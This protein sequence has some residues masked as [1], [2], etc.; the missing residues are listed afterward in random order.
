L[1]AE[2]HPIDALGEDDLAQRRDVDQLGLEPVREDEHVEDLADAVLSR[3]R[4]ERHVVIERIV[5]EVPE[6]LFHVA[7]RP[8]REEVASHGLGIMHARTAS[9][10]ADSLA[11]LL[12]GLAYWCWRFRFPCRRAEKLRHAVAHDGVLEE[13][14][15]P[16]GGNEHGA[17]A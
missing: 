10:A 6:Q 2:G 5:R 14:E 16:A 11:S 15:V 4:L 7:P 9:T 12:G 1:A 13:A 17:A 8:G 3:H